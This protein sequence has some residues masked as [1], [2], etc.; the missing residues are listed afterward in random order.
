MELDSGPAATEPSSPPPSSGRC[1]EPRIVV[2]VSDLQGHLRVDP[3]ALAGV[4][5]RTLEAEGIRAAEL[6]IGVVDDAAIRVL[7]RRHL[8][9]DWPT[10]VISFPLS[11][12]GA[13]AL[14]GE[15]V[16]SAEMAVTT[17]RRAGLDPHAELALY[18]VHGVLHLCGRDDQDPGTIAV[19]RRREAEVLAAAGLPN[20]Y[21]MAGPAE[22]GRETLR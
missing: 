7:N 6:S 2:E 8:G 22:P 11:G 10:D 18:L 13:A 12:P 19:M 3:A 4:A 14:A 9:H 5:R 1:A 17:A 20:T 16:V 15:V 21:P